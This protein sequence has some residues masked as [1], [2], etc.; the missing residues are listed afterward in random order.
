M[1]KLSWITEFWQNWL[2]Y[3]EFQTINSQNSW[4]LWELWHHLHFMSLLGTVPWICGYKST[5][6]ILLRLY[7]PEVSQFEKM[8]KLQ[9]CSRNSE[10]FPE[11]QQRSRSMYLV[12]LQDSGPDQKEKYGTTSSFDSICH[13]INF[14]TWW[15]PPCEKSYF[16]S[17]KFCTSGQC[18][19][20][21]DKVTR[22]AMSCNLGQ[23][24]RFQDKVTRGTMSCNSGQC[25]RL[26]DEVW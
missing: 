4:Q 19:R 16:M 7:S 15:T 3:Q 9:L 11:L 5:D 26:R 24:P 21:Q 10:Q 8:S 25:P 22:D 6:M 1:S 18:P 2:S 20:L 14:G 12:L 17:P 23:C 13:S